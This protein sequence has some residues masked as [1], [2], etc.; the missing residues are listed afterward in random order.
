MRM[1]RKIYDRMLEWKRDGAGKCALMIEGA[2]RVGKSWIVEEFGK[3]EYESCLVIDFARVGTQI[4]RLFEEKLDDLD[5]FFMLLE[6]RTRVGLVPGK[7]LVVFDEV[8]RFPRAREAIKYLVEDGR[9]HYIE[10]GSL[11]SIRRNVERIVIPSEEQKIQMYPMDFEEFLW[12]LDA[13]PVMALIR[14]RFA[15]RKPMGQSDHRMAMELFR[16]YVVVGGMPQAV[17]AFAN[18][19]DLKSAERAKRLVLDL[20][21][22]DIGKFAGR[23]KHKVRAIWDNIPGALSAQEKHFRPGLVAEGVRMREL[24]APFEWLAESMTVNMASNVTAPNAGLKMTE[25]RVLVK[26][27]MGDTGLLVS[28]AFAENREAA[29]DMQWKILTGK[30][31]INKGMLMENAVAQMLVSAGQKLFFHYGSSAD[32]M[33]IDFL[34]AKSRITA[35]HNIYPVEVKSARDYTTA[36]LDKF[37]KKYASSV[38]SPI[39]Q[40]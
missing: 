21:R 5:E 27:Y 26:C 11:V 38:A 19:R 13:A 32:R 20:Y 16:Q 4:R 31:E 14:R 10:T 2:R 33:E 15:E 28:H 40:S 3:N 17:A 29:M 22:D 37:R 34:L 25:D 36:S 23:L 6:A 9:F 30:L 35:R 1:K 12:A 24:D 7:S 39:R 8:Q 18:G